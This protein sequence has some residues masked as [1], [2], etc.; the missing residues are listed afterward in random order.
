MR[1]ALVSSSAIEALEVP[2]RAETRV[3]HDVLRVV[4]VRVRYRANVLRSVQV[5]QHDS[6]EAFELA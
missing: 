4:R 2:D 3:L 5:R 6:F 1:R